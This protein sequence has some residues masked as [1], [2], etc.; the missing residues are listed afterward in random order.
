[1]IVVVEVCA[2]LLVL[3]HNYSPSSEQS[4]QAILVYKQ[5]NQLPVDSNRPISQILLLY[6]VW[7]Y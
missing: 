5:N 4:E 3:F 2:L 7:G 6:K 1:M